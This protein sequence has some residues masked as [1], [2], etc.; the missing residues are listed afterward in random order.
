[1]L[2]EPAFANSESTALPVGAT[3]T[4]SETW[5]AY[6][7]LLNK[8]SSLD[9]IVRVFTKVL[10][11]VN[12]LKLKLTPHSNEASKAQSPKIEFALEAKLLLIRHDQK[13]HFSS[14]LEYLVAKDNS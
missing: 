6:T 12:L 14:V 3:S 10:K 13:I 8:S 1:M 11:F 4:V 7:S 9:Y 2:R 5:Q